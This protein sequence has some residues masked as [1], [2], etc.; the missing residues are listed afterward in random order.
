MGFIEHKF[1]LLVQHTEWQWPLVGVH[2]IMMEKLAQ[3]GEDG[4]A[5]PTSFTLST[6]T[7]K[8]VV[9]TPAERAEPFSLFLFYPFGFSVVR[10]LLDITNREQVTSC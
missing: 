7:Y 6:I 8:V 9:Y 1:L 4:G 5:R 10:H 3:A 2:S